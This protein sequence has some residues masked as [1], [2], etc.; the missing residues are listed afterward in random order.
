VAAPDWLDKLEKAYADE[1]VLGAGG[2]IQPMWVSGP[3]KWVPEEFYWVMGCM[4]LGFTNEFKKV[5]S[6]FGSNMSFRRSMMDEEGF[7]INL[8]LVNGKQGVG[9]EAELAMRL[10]GKNPGHYIVHTPDAVVYHKIFDFRKSMRHLFRRAYA[11]GMHIGY[12]RREKDD[13]QEDGFGDDRGMVSF[14]L[15]KSLPERLKRLVGLSPRDMPY[16]QEFVRTAMVALSS[17]LVASG[18]AVGRLKK[19]VGAEHKV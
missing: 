8:G 9:E 18:M 17:L 6:N 12:Y 7:N 3:A 16:S 15:F 14:V 1:R 4:Y 11:Y 19:L 13:G 5:R 10:V 2:P